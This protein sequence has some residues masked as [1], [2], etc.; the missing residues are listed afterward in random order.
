MTSI[1]GIHCRRAALACSTALTVFTLPQAVHA[2]E[3]PQ[4]AEEQAI[5]VT[6]SRIVRRDYEAN[7]PIVTAG[8]ELLQRSST[9][10]LE[11][12][13]NKLPN[14]TPVQTPSLG[15]DIQ[16]TATNTPG[17]ATVSLRGL[18]TNRS[19]VLVDGRRTTPANALGVVDINTI[20]SAAIERVEIITGGASATYGA[21][22]VAGVVNFIL[23]KNFQGLQLDAQM[24]ISQRGDGQEYS[25]SGI[26]GSNFE[27]GRG[28]ITIGLSVNNRESA[29]RRD[30]PWFRDAWQDPRF[31][32]NEFFPYFSG[33]QPI[34]SN[35]PSQAV[36]NS[37]FSGA[38]PGA[39][40]AGSRLYF[41]EDGTAFSGFF[42]S[43]AAGAY[44]FKGDLTGLKYKRQGDG[45]LGQ[46]FQDELLL[47][48]LERYNIYTRGN[49]E[50]NDWVGVF[51]QGTFTRVQTRTINQPSPSV[52]GWSAA[53]PNDGRAIPTELATILNSRADPTGP[54][55][56]TYYL[57]FMNRESKTDVLTYNMVA[58]FEGKIPGTDWTWE[59]Y[60]SQGESETSSLITG[61]ASLERFRAVI[62]APN[63][64][65]GFRAQGNA[66]FGGFGASSAT[67]T[68]GFDPFNKSTPISQ[69]CI[70]A[71]SA[72]LSNRAVMQQTVFEANAQGG[73]FELPAGQARVAL[74]AS[75]RQNA[76]DF[77][78]DTLTEQGTSFLDQTIGI[79]PSGSSA[80][81]IRSKELYGE[82]LIPILADLPLVKKFELNLGAR[83]ADYNTT[84]NAFTWKAAGDWEVTDWLRVRGGYN[85]AI[86][87]PNVAE[88]YLAPQQTFT[89]AGGG[90]VCRLNNTLA[91]SA[92]P[93]ANSN[94]ANVRAVC[95]ILMNQNDG[96]SGRD[97]AAVFY[98]DPQFYNALGPA[99]AFPTLVGNPNIKPETAKTWTLG[100]VINSPSSNEFFRRLR[101]SVDYYNIK[102]DDAIGPLTLDT[103]QRACFDPTFNPAI[104]SNPTA[105]AAT[106]QC[107]AIG[108]VTGDGALG[109]VQVTYLNNG[110]FRTQGIDAQLD[111]AFPVGPGT[112]S[113]NTVFNYLLTLKSAPLPASA[114]AAGQL[115]EYAGTLGPAGSNAIAEN[116]LNPGA[117]R[118]KLFN[119][120]TY[121]VGPVSV[122]LQWQHL[123]AAKSIAY[124]SNNATPFVGAPA[125][126]L[127]NL[128]GSFSVTKTA[129]LRWGVDNLFDKAPPLVEYNASSTGLA[130]GIG[131]SPFNAYFYDLNGRRF[132][133]GGSF[134]F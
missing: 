131:A 85:K 64:G 10:A 80:G 72:P 115:V 125:Y 75:Y 14:F 69:D 74:G 122:S 21:D 106:A 13:L 4:A 99:F 97:T 100:A 124:T 49:Y 68:S 28:N 45:T 27:D 7:S 37:I 130:N 123:P 114:G 63:W 107:Q 2:Q 118:W 55:Q 65:A 77:H 31:T 109:N 8:E 81:T 132:Y 120:F 76:Y 111:W 70:D 119:T 33:Y 17:A 113:L 5:V 56:L 79:Y 35:T 66:A 20:P 104:T 82:L 127:F 117:F 60:G 116:G 12:N 26:M 57:D 96:T 6:G 41:N 23:K 46:N 112:F 67:C 93:A 92:N 47:L 34:G 44:R 62:S 11:T 19:L 87:A 129:S 15:G 133:I 50:I 71:I 38:A 25:I 94:A 22:A 32:G 48:P 110:R 101:L 121:G 134:K 59:V 86:R 53:I 91:W 43:P 88:L 108:R 30:R 1:F 83:N 9:A 52:N 36:M 18:G 78:N 73:L 16:P 3:A 126:D 24:G 39:V 95:S 102:V 51:A 54:W 61:T 29:Y 103:A 90:D 105:A 42:Q 89:A 58:G 98:G 40:G 128:N 84:G